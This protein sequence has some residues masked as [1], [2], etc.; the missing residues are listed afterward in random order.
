M[1]RILSS[2]NKDSK[3]PNQSPGLGGPGLGLSQGPLQSHS[4]SKGAFLS[5]R[6][7]IKSAVGR[8]VYKNGPG[9]DAAAG[10]WEGR[11]G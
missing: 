11:G 10:C 2:E 5:L 9:R 3:R 8:T 1:S 4:F 6:K 7:T